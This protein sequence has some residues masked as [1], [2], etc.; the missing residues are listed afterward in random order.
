MKNK[1][2]QEIICKFL[3]MNQDFRKTIQ[4]FQKITNFNYTNMCAQNYHDKFREIIKRKKLR[5]NSGSTTVR[6]KSV[7]KKQSSKEVLSARNKRFRKY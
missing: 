2:R 5:Q 1:N 3:E 7:P 6:Y 4:N